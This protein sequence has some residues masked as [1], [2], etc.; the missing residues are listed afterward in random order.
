MGIVGY[1][2][3]AY[4]YYP[5]SMSQWGL[6]W[7]LLGNMLWV[8]TYALQSFV[9][10]SELKKIPFYQYLLVAG[11]FVFK[12]Y[13]DRFLGTFI[14]TTSSDYPEFLKNFFGLAIITIHAG[15]FVGTRKIDS[16]KAFFVSR[17]APSEKKKI[18][19]EATSVSS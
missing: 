8:T 9:I 5:V 16:I 19:S 10:A 13:A 7:R 3:M 1:G 14:D 11:Y 18:Y 4:I 15:V 12:D 6:E 2:I 17:F